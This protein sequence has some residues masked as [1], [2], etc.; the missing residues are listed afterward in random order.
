MNGIRFIRIIKY[1]Y[2][3]NQYYILIHGNNKALVG[4]AGDEIVALQS[5]AAE[6]YTR[7]LESIQTI[8]QYTNGM[9]ARL[10]GGERKELPWI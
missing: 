5:T 8:T 1:R 3:G 6:A 4:E 7:G 10:W 9:V 2:E